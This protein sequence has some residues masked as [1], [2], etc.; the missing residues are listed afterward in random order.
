MR[1]RKFDYDEET[2]EFENDGLPNVVLDCRHD[3]FCDIYEYT[4]EGDYVKELVVKDGLIVGLSI[5]C[6]FGVCDK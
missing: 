6:N 4:R 3:I 5:G 2:I 1:I